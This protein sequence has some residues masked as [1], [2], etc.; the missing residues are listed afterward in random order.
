MPIIIELSI[1][2]G[3]LIIHELAHYIHFRAS[4][5]KPKL[6]FAG[7]L[8]YVEPSVSGVTVHQMM[9]NI[10]MAITAGYA[11]LSIMHTTALI[12]FA[13]TVGCFIDLN[14]FQMFVLWLS[15]KTI[16]MRTLVDD[17]KIVVKNRQ[18]N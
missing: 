16:T 17:I 12:I 3:A 9:S 14:N 18:L 10:I 5:Y 4:G 13:Y 15:R 11:F 8:V 2:I 1:L 7:M 6:K